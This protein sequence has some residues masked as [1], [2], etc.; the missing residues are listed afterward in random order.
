MLAQEKL[1]FYFTYQEKS[2]HD[3]RHTEYL[4]DCRSQNL[5]YG[6]CEQSPR[7]RRV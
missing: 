3:K 5:D 6:R 7:P 4:T 1:F 2:V